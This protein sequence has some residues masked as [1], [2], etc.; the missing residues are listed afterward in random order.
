[1]RFRMQRVLAVLVMTMLWLGA[2]TDR[3][4]AHGFEL[5]LDGEGE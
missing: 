3:V 5:E 2:A 1:M 4:A